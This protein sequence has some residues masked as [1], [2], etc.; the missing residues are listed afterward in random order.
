MRI[1]A[2]DLETIPN[3]SIPDECKP[4]FNPS[5]V[6]TGNIK[7]PVKIQEKIKEQEQVFIDGLS[8]TMSIDPALCQLCLFAGIEFDT[9][10]DEIIKEHILYVDDENDDYEPVFHGWELLIAAYYERIPIV[11]FNGKGFD[12]PIMLFRAIQQDINVD[13]KAYDELTYRYI[14]DRH[15]DLL[16]L[17]AGWDRSKWHNLDFYLKLF[18]LGA[19][20]DFDGSMVYSAYIAGEHEKIK[21]Y[22]R[23]DVLDTCNLFSRVDSW[24]IRK[25]EVRHD[26][27]ESSPSY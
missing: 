17:L 23:K 1:F 22:G 5:S 3:Q 16:Q 10:K 9:E 4:A 15:Y 2:F 19:K 8:K 7:D 11:T 13:M 6:K 25:Q 12:F 14:N 27:D 24:V 18:G 26:I 20:G 21:Q